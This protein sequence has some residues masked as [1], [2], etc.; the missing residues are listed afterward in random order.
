MA[1]IILNYD[2]QTA[3]GKRPTDRLIGITNFPGDAKIMFKKRIDT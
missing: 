2:V 3:D 1:H